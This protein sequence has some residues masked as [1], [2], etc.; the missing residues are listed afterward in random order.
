MAEAAARWVRPASPARRISCERAYRDAGI[1]SHEVGY[2]EAHGTGTRAG[3]AVE[4]QALSDVMG[5]ERQVGVPLL[6]GSVKTNLGHTEGAAGVAGL[7][8]AALTVQHGFV[9]ASLNFDERNPRI[10]WAEMPVT[11]AGTGTSW[12]GDGPRRA[13]VSSFGIAGTNA[14]VVLEEPPHPREVAH[15]AARLPLLTVSA[16]SEAAVR[17]LALRLADNLAG[18]Q[19]LE[20]MAEIV[21]YAQRRRAAHACRAVFLAD[22]PARLQAALRDYAAGGAAFAE[23]TASQSKPAKVAFVFPGQGGQWKGMARELIETA[24]AFRDA[25]SRA[26]EVIRAETGW[27]LVERL[28]QDAEGDA[29]ERIDFVQP[30]LAAI[31]IAYAA[32]LQE[33][34][35]EVA[36]VVGHSM[37]E[38]AAAHVAGALS[39]EDALRIV[40]IRSRLM[41]ELS[42]KGAM[43]L[44][45]LPEADVT[46]KLARYEGRVSIAAINSP[47]ACVISGDKDAVA[48]LVEAFTAEGAFSR[49]INVDVASHSPQMERPAEALRTQLANL[50]ARSATFPF[51][52]SVRGRTIDG[53]ELDAGYWAHNLRKPVRFCDALHALDELGISA[54]VELG[55]HPVLTPSIER[56]AASG[57]GRPHTVVCC[58]RRDEP[59]TTLLLSVL[60][61]LW[62]TGAVIDWSRGDAGPVKVV[63]FPRYPW[64][65][66]RHWVEN[67]EI[68]RGRS[69]SSTLRKIPE[70]HRQWLHRVVWRELAP[71]GSARAG[72]SWAVIGEAPE[73]IQGLVAAGAE[74]VQF[75]LASLEEEVAALGKS[76]LA[77]NVLVVAT[78]GEEAPFLPLRVAR[79]LPTGSS[80]R[81]WFATRGG[82]SPTGLARIDADQGALWGCARVLSSE[83]PDVWG[84]LIDLPVGMLDA[85]SVAQAAARLLDPNGE[86]QIAVRGGRAYAPRLVAASE[87]PGSRITWRSDC[88]YLLTGGLGDVGLCVAQQLVKE[89]ARRLILM[90]RTALPPRREWTSVDATS[91]A[92]KRITGVRRLESM[93]ASVQC[94]AVDVSDEAAVREFL[95]G[96]EAEGWP[97]IRGVLHLAAKLDRR[98]IE[99][100]TR[101]S[102]EADL[103]AKLRSA[104]VLDRLLPDLDCF[105]LFS[106]QIT[107]IPQPGMSAYA[108]ANAGLE[109]LAIDRRAR[110]AAASA[111]VW[112]QWRGAGLISGDI[113]DAVTR[114]LEAR[115]LNAFEPSDAAALL[116]YVAGREEPVM[117][118]IAADWAAFSADRGSLRVPLL[119]ELMTVSRGGGAAE[120]MAGASLVERRAMLAA[121]VIQALSRTLR[122]PA[123]RI[124]DA[125]P[126]GAM[127]LTSILAMEL[128]NRLERE[129]SRPLSV[130]LAWNYPSVEAL[131]SFLAGEPEARDTEKA[132]AELEPALEVTHLVSAISSETDAEVI[133]GLRRPRRS[134][135]AG[136]RI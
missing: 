48:A 38:A 90:G 119:S 76:R 7:I 62:C 77:S 24:P 53:R 5:R 93:G 51:V 126:F 65:R 32:W 113:G 35:V 128:R 133:D 57:H 85:D 26:E 55:P 81:L 84:G 61:R 22:D 21:A 72:A 68:A 69:G 23:G 107:L 40:C 56:S 12:R 67:A 100:F 136:K 130:T 110:G 115:G 1:R 89:G 94:A 120:R 127:G 13:G 10:P 75:P 63:D 14:H 73:L 30:A 106:S 117:S 103:R 17:E 132:S 36:A 108:A 60:A 99:H 112:G 79:A 92:G 50:M 96:Y 16:R 86:D 33:H 129:L 102:F 3:D 104:Q 58:G 123:E 11:I 87:E 39:L 111:V 47:Q 70:E 19:R 80:I 122:I 118:V 98:L 64:Q 59:E 49:L 124:D 97:P 109:V 116:S 28:Q 101:E 131:A 46:P 54:V 18:A 78:E 88:A 45:D 66:Q 29:C 114:E 71:A 135:A 6:V 125:T 2:V 41:L 27:S 44:V 15:Q 34:G 31:S 42:G 95:A 83:R 8:K 4:L 52:S 25:L 82:R 105:V 74:V 91:R 20:A 43:A 9:P 37:G 134:R 121:T